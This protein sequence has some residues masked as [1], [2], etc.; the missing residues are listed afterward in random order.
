M[1]LDRSRPIYCEECIEIVREERRSG[2]KQEKTTAKI[3]TPPVKEG[4]MVLK[5]VVGEIKLAALGMK[6]KE[7]VAEKTEE[8]KVTPVAEKPKPSAS[9]PPEPKKPAPPPQ[10]QKPKPVAP[11]SSGE[12]VFP[13]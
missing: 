9:K 7:A 1:E 3:N 4:D 8:K 11:K 6:E 2:R 10:Q 13:W 5:N 12:D